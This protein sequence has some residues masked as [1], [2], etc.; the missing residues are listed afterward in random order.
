MVTGVVLLCFVAKS[1]LKIE[2]GE[3]GSRFLRRVQLCPE[4]VLRGHRQ[5]SKPFRSDCVDPHA[6]R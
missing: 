2:N 4:E 6:V 5:E 1:K 3:G